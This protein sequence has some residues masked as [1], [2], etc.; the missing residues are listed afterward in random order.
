MCKPEID[1]I[2]ERPVS[3]PLHP[4][5]AGIL[6]ELGRSEGARDSREDEAFYRTRTNRLRKLLHSCLQFT[7]LYVEDPLIV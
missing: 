5:C 7:Q 4:L 3:R 1:K 2:C 6:P